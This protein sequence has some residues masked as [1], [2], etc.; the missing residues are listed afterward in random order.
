MLMTTSG[1]FKNRGTLRGDSPGVLT[2]K[3]GGF[4]GGREGVE[5]GVGRVF[6]EGEGHSGTGRSISS[7]KVYL[8]AGFPL[9]V[10]LPVWP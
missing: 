3:V 4:L 1:D 5:K 8:T 7:R 9:Q 2:G 6:L 10:D